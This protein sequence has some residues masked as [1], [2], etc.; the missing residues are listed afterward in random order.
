MKFRIDFFGGP[1]YVHRILCHFETANGYTT[2]ISCLTRSIKNFIFLKDIDSFQRARHICAFTD[3][4]CSVLYYMFRIFFIELVLSGAWQ[5]NIDFNFPWALAGEK[6]Y[7]ELFGI[8]FDSISSA[9]AHLEHIIYL[10]TLDTIG[11]VNIAIGT[12]KCYNLS[13]ESSRFSNSTPC[14]ITETG[15]SHSFTS[16]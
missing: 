16:E 11:V 13:T 6:F 2:G 10:L 14:D 1:T 8:I 15:Y 12:G 9:G 4:D 5:A 3:S 7:S